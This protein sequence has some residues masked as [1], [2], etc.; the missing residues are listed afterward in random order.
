MVSDEVNTIEV[1]YILAN[2]S[3]KINQSPS[4]RKKTKQQ[5]PNAMIKSSP[6]DKFTPE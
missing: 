3:R 2:Y 4:P 5:K 6:L 1:D